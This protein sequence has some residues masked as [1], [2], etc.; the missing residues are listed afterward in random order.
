M[1]KNKYPE[2]EVYAPNLVL[3]PEQTKA[4]HEL[5]LAGAALNEKIEALNALLPDNTYTQFYGNW[6]ILKI[7]QAE[8]E[9]N[10]EQ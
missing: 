6:N 3:T 1:T 10:P 9:S 8:P 2:G 4:A 7:K 5:L